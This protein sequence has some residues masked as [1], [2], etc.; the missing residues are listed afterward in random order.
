[1]KRCFSC[2]PS[3]SESGRLILVAIISA[4]S[5]CIA[6]SLAAATLTGTVSVERAK[7]R[8]DGPKHDRDL[9]IFLRPLEAPPKTS[10]PARAVMD[11][12]GLVFLPH[13]LAIQQGTTVR[14]LNSD[15]E[16]HNVYFLDDKTGETLDIGTWGPGIS[17]DHKFTSPGAVI[18]LCKLHLEMAAYVV[19][20][21]G[22]W[23]TQA[24]F[25]SGS[26]TATFEIEGIPP[27]EY[28]LVVWHKK[29]KLKGG[30]RR[31]SFGSGGKRSENLVMT[32]AQYAR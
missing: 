19:V 7:I 10:P 32:K 17:V 8:T 1:M 30:V 22:P 4:A 21:P 6:G 29:L 16:N 25:D 13:V 26:G 23:F 9:V 11:Q 31:L 28:E 3:H 12:K 15:T 20:S 14:F 18:V 5:V 2:L 27:G 24:Q